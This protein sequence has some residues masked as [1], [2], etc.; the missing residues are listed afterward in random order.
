MHFSTYV[1]GWLDRA[2]FSDNAEEKKHAD[3]MLA[4]LT[5]IAKA[6]LTDTSLE[7]AIIGQ[8]VFGGHG[9]IREWGQEQHVRDIRITQIYEG[10]N[11]IQALDLMGRKIVGNNGRVS[12]S[13]SNKTLT[14]L[15]LAKQQTR[16][17]LS[18][19]NL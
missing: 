12:T 9:F 19:S 10:T 15:L 14:T 4:L 3:A 5:P 6:F 1:A 17:R 2:K 13:C 18:L 11:G 7:V 8:Q 16:L